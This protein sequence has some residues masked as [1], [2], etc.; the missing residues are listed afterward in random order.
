MASGKFPDFIPP[1]KIHYVGGRPKELRLR[2]CKLVYE[3][4][5]GPVERVFD[6]P[7]INI[8]SHADNDIV[9]D[10]DTVSRFHC[11]I[12]QGEDSYILTDLDSTNGTAIH[13]V[14]IREAYLHPG[15]TVSA[16]QSELS[17]FALDERF[18][19]VPSKRDRCGDLIGSTI[20]MR[21]LFGII[22]KIAPSGATVVIEGETGTG[23]EVVAQS[24]HQLSNRSR[25]PFTVFDCGAVPANL[26][27]SEL[28]GHEKGSFTGA[29][30]TRQGLFEVAQRGT[31]FLD[32]LG[33][34]DLDLQPKLLRVLEQR[35][36][37]RVGSTK[38][39]KID[40]RVIAATNRNLAEEVKAGRFREDL[41]YRLSVVRLMLPALRERTEDIPL[42]CEHLLGKLTFNR[43]SDG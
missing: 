42:L 21:E 20:Q 37:R 13:R 17:F 36:V 2:K 16:G 29:S 8:G 10:D 7:V 6:E 9:L 3:G 11:K 30:S 27:E 23:K 33:E 1:T 39:L 4:P 12:Y 25:G 31:I 14:R 22:E 24:I 26:I 43:S 5:D 35:E 40:V 19:V 28:F 41:F 18:K 15:C 38:P 32:E 34:L